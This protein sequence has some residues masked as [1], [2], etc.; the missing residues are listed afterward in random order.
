MNPVHGK[1]EVVLLRGAGG[2][3]R[4]GSQETER[5]TSTSL[6]QPIWQMICAYNLHIPKALEGATNDK[7][8]CNKL[9]DDRAKPGTPKPAPWE[10]RQLAKFRCSGY[11][12]S[13]LPCSLKSKSFRTI[14][15][16]TRLY[17]WP[18]RSNNRDRDSAQG[19]VQCTTTCQSR[20]AHR[21][22][23]SLRKGCDA[24]GVTAHKAPYLALV[25]AEG[26]HKWHRFHR[27]CSRSRVLAIGQ[28]LLRTWKPLEQVHVRIRFPSI[29]PAEA[30]QTVR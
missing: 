14:G 28:S 29:S 3:Q 6:P 21:L 24:C 1:L 12:V 18:C 8:V 2:H 13:Y 16:W 20:I 25:T 19:A 15:R 17:V 9:C 10:S 5:S 30:G 4:L 26:P 22:P 7:S 11:Q 27:L 23:I